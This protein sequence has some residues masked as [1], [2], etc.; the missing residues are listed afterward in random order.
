MLS[1]IGS[2]DH[3]FLSRGYGGE[4]T[5]AIDVEALS[6]LPTSNDLAGSRPRIQARDDQ[7]QTLSLEVILRDFAPRRDWAR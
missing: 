7:G 1:Q 4:I 6:D 3:L 5:D 2:K